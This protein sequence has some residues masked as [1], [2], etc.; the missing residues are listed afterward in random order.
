MFRRAMSPSGS[1][2]HPGWF[3][4]C[5]KPVTPG[6]ADNT[7]VVGSSGLLVRTFVQ[8][9]CLDGGVRLDLREPLGVVHIFELLELVL[10]TGSLASL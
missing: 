9:S 6:V 5:S 4:T 3:L 1:F 2:R 8:S 7:S 10:A